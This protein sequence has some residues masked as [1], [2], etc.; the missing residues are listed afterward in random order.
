MSLGHMTSYEVA[1][2]GSVAL[3]EEVWHYRRESVTMGVDVEVSFA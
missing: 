1:P 3:L 2:L